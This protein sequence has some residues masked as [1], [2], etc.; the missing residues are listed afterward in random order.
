MLHDPEL[1]GASI[2]VTEVRVSP[3]LKNA[4]AFVV[5]LGGSKLEGVTAALNRASGFLRHELSHEIELRFL[6][7]LSFEPD[8]SF[9]AA[10]RIETLL[11]SPRVQHDLEKVEPDGQKDEEGG[12]GT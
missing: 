12:D 7:R 6:P 3:D 9:D 11:H 5:P 2:T 4:V 10:E 1:V 8:R